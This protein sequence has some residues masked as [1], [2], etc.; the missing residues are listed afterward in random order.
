[1]PT[2]R[3]YI[4]KQTYAKQKQKYVWPFSGH[5]VLEG[6]DFAIK[7]G[8]EKKTKNDYTKTIYFYATASIWRDQ[9]FSDVAANTT[10][11]ENWIFLKHYFEHRANWCL[12]LIIMW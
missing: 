8:F 4:L 3:S 1:M 9:Q 10:P 2:K 7:L 12:G 6:L 11:K 5:Q